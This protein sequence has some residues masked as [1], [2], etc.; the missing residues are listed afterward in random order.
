MGKI[1]NDSFLFQTILLVIVPAV[2]FII[3]LSVTGIALIIRKKK[4]KD[5]EKDDPKQSE[6]GDDSDTHN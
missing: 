5:S 6:S 2:L 3:M 4:M 1:F